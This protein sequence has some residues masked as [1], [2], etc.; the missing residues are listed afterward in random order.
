MD[1]LTDGVDRQHYNVLVIGL[2]IRIGTYMT[3]KISLEFR[4]LKYVVQIPSINILSTTLRS[5]GV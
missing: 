4:V 3:P 2:L 5:V 1:K